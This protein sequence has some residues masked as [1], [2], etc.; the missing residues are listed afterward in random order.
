MNEAPRGLIDIREVLT[1]LAT[2]RYMG[3]AEAAQY[4]GVSI[5]TLEARKDIPRFQLQGECGKGGKVLF[6]KS[7]LDRWMETN[8]VTG[9][10][11][12]DLARLAD[13]ALAAVLGGRK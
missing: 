3:K 13:E 10:E 1:Y 9:N 12:Q 2:D 5:R 11:Q 6:R 8:R 4:L 7:E